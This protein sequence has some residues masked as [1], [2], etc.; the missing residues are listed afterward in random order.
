MPKSPKIKKSQPL[1][2]VGLMTY[3]RPKEFIRSFK[4][5]VG[6]TYQNLEIIVSEN[7]SPGFDEKAALV[8]KTLK[9]DK[10]ISYFQHKPNK[11]IYFNINFV[12][13]KATGKYFMW[14][15]DDDY[16]APEYIAKL[17]REL[18]NHPE[19]GVALSAINFLSTNKPPQLISF[20]GPYNPNGKGFYQTFWFALH[21]A[22]SRYYYFICGLFRRELFQKPFF[23]VADFY[24]PDLMF[25]V[26]FSLI[27]PFRYVDKP[28]FYCSSAE[29][30]YRQKEERNDINVFRWGGEI[31]N[32]FKLGWTILTCPQ[33]RWKQKPLLLIAFFALTFRLLMLFLIKF[34]GYLLKFNNAL[35]AKV[36]NLYKFLT[37]R[38]FCSK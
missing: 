21:P 17:V 26:L 13:K 12:L 28:L 4:S 8:K 22:I 23:Q 25:I 10:R 18:E 24:T 30:D 6:Q 7:Y 9:K 32:P 1:V 20:V 3:Q 5:I 36:F 11:G 29:C 15:A 19:A 14:A 37:N 31:E 33:V 35:S 38:Y 2:S 34:L 27:A 16:W